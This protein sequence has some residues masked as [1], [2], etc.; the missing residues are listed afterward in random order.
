MK[1]QQ[2]PITEAESQDFIKTLSALDEID[3]KAPIQER[4]NAFNQIAGGFLDKLGRL[5]PHLKAHLKRNR[6]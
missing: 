6:N 1:K 5:P 3:P 4:V 2:K